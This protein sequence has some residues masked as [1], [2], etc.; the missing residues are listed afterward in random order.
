MKVPKPL[1][2]S[3]VGRLNKD[4]EYETSPEIQNIKEKINEI[5]EYLEEKIG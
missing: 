5:I 3:H 4:Y 2:D 1:K